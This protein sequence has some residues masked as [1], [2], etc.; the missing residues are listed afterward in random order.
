MIEVENGKNVHRSL[1]NPN[2]MSF[3]VCNYMK[4]TKKKKENPYSGG[5]GTS[6]FLA[7]LA[8]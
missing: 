6:T 2:V 1:P 5:A 8:L 7:F 4:Q 3:S